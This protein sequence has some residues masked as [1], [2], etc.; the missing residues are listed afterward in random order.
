[1]TRRFTISTDY[2]NQPYA[3]DMDTGA[4]YRFHHYPAAASDNGAIQI[5]L[6]REFVDD[7]GR[8]LAWTD[9]SNF[10]SMLPQIYEAEYS[11]ADDE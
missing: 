9:G 8:F 3:E 1:M 11:G 5:M 10:D 7:M 4:R 6:A 2:Y